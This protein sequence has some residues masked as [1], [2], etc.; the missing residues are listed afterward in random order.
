MRTIEDFRASLSQ[1]LAS[2]DLIQVAHCEDMIREWEQYQFELMMESP[3]A[4]AAR[5]KTRFLANPNRGREH[6][7]YGPLRNDLG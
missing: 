3:E 2:R 4:E 6:F 5:W 1:A 7:V